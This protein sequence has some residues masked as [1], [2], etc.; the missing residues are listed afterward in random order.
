MSPR[1]VSTIAQHELLVNIRNKWTLTFAFVFGLLV[2]A[3]SYFGL[4]TLGY[5]QMQDFSRTV[6]SLLNLVL[7]VIPL[8]ALV[9][10]TMSFASEK[11]S[12]ELLFAQPV[13]RLEILLG[14]TAGLFGSLLISTLVGFG[15]A[16]IL[17]GMRTGLDGSLRYFAFVGLS[18]V[19]ALI[20]LVV[21]ILVS[22]LLRRKGKSFGV[23]LFVWF[24]FVILYDL[25]VM[26]GASLMV[27]KAARWLLFLSV[28]GNP[29]DMVRISGLIAIDGTA[30]FG[31][32]GAA[33]V[34]FLGGTLGSALALTSAMA[35]WIVL[36]LY[37]A[38][39]SL[40]S[41]DV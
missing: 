1:I 7:Y 32:A 22:V 14:K 27:G 20:F 19:L 37:L 3:I 4:R 36:P 2:L 21:A 28:F 13:S 9:M 29:V 30:I 39:R 34:R 18:L 8:V 6:A 12:A 15:L 40:R 38:S 17:I 24:F 33:L 35:A 23:V 31:P 26:G 11:E 10:G 5:A 25:L 16:G 41:Q